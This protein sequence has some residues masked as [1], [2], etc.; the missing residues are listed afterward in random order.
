MTHGGSQRIVKRANTGS[1]SL[2]DE[3]V[4]LMNSKPVASK[5]MAHLDNKGISP[6]FPGAAS[7]KEDGL[8]SQNEN[9]SC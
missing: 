7:G 4:L 3:L 9:S 5:N 1:S 6:P 2:Q 8:L